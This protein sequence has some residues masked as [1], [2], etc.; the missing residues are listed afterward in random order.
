M[1]HLGSEPTFEKFYLL[2]HAMPEMCSSKLCVRKCVAVGCSGLQWVA[3]SCSALYFY[4]LLH[5]MPQ[6]SSCELRV[7]KC[8]AVCCSVLQWVA[9]GCSVLQWVAV[10]CSVLQF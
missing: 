4:L 7:R 9:E 10:C 8:V 5:A 2:L 6:M 3:V 1:R